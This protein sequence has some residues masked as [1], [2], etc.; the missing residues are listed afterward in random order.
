MDGFNFRY[1]LEM[2][3]PTI[4]LC[5]VIGKRK[6]GLIK[7][8]C[9]IAVSQIF[10]YAMILAAKNVGYAETEIITGMAG[11]AF[12]IGWFIVSWLFVVA[13]I[14]L[15]T[16][17]TLYEAVYIFAVSYSIEHIFY[18]IRSLVE[19]VSN[20]K[21]LADQPVIYM[22]CLIG[23]FLLAY[24]WFAK[25][26]VKNGRFYVE[27][28]TATSATIGILLIVWL[29]S[30]VSGIFGFTYLHCIYAILSCIFILSNQRA[31]LIRENERAEFKVK[32]QIWKDTQ[33]RYEISK[34]AMAI[35][36]QHY[37]DMKHQ[38]SALASMEDD[39]KRRGILSEMENDIAVYDAVVRTGNEYLDTVLT[40]KK[41]ICHS[42]HI[43]MSCIADGSQLSFME[44]IDLYTLMGNAL[45]NAIEANEKI[46]DTAR[47]WIS[48]QIQDKKGI[49]LVEIINP[50]EG[51]I[52]MNGDVPETSKEDK[53]SHGFGSG[54]IKAI[55]EKY[56]GQMII[57]TDNNKY[58][59]RLIFTEN[60]N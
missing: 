32:E 8:I 47:R 52:K 25:G 39:E 27:T 23:S 21:I 59:L 35:V 36:N 18:C 30:L 5:I 16:E 49:V 14:Y 3:M 41:L 42:K 12:I 58:L 15:W 50:Y 29:L 53:I 2:L 56:K 10:N 24:Y 46:A 37:H 33:A 57:K 22:A 7:A 1:L 55:T 48:V 13:S 9:C 11:Y 60:G 6:N 31:Q 38:I 54:S 51:D 45:D 20:G 4:G 44:E 17:V 28:V 26:T 40:E 19:Y 34:D 43:Q